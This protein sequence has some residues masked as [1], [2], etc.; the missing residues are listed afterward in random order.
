[1]TAIQEE[2]EALHKNKTWKLVPLPHG[3]KVIGYMTN[4]GGEHWIAVKR[5]LIY[6]RG[7]S[8][9]TL[10]YGGS[11]FTVT[12]YVDSDFTGDLDKR[13]STTLHLREQL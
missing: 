7:T 5:I 9:V 1:M 12:G 6:I 4:P 8:D 13:K 3:R 10:C 2:I 11:E